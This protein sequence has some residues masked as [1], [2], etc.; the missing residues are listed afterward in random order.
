MKRK[1]EGIFVVKAAGMKEK[2]YFDPTPVE[3]EDIKNGVSFEIGH[4]GW[5]VIPYNELIQ[6]LT[7]ADRVRGFKAEE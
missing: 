2:F 3:C 6:M 4:E 1:K 5:F 7:A